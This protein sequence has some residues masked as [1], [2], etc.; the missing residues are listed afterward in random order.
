ML[1]IIRPFSLGRERSMGGR[2]GSSAG[3][4]VSGVGVGWG[5]V[6]GVLIDRVW[7]RTS[8]V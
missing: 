1:S 4:L 7:A 3:G 8:E 6:V 5:G 2:I